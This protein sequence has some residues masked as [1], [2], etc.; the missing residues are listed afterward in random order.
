MTGPAAL[1]HLITGVAELVAAAAHWRR[2]NA[3]TLDTEF[4]RT[5]T[6]YPR[7]ALVQV[8]DGDTA[9]LIDPVA[10]GDLR[11]LGALLSD[12]NVVKVLHSCSEDLEV[13]QHA[14]GCRPAPLYDTQV[15][16][17]MVGHGFSLGYST[18]VKRLL[19]IE[20]GKQETRSDW[21]QRPLS[22]AQ[23]AYAAA[24][25]QHLF[26]VYHQ[27]VEVG[28]RLGRTDWIA[29]EMAAILAQ[30][31][32]ETPPEQQYRR[33]KG[34]GRLGGRELAA[35]R[36]LAAWR[37]GEARRRDRPRGHIV[38]DVEL[39]ALVQA[40]PADRAA[41]ARIDDLRPRTARDHGAELL[42][43]LAR[44]AQVPAAEFPEPLDGEP[45]SRSARDL[46]RACRDW[47][48]ERAAAIEIAPEMLVRRLDLEQLARSW[49]GG[50]PQLPAV[51]AVGWRH[52]LVGTELLDFVR[53]W[54]AASP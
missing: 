40:R 33:V 20:I 49:S 24:D 38:N 26:P 2:C 11:P 34:A 10:L 22:A 28:A 39:L 3:V 31:A 6:F 51:L 21:L 25:V 47:L 46:V 48:A 36:E 32:Q 1:A 8:S 14:L 29:A 4:M 7:L 12:P 16:A 42:A 13:L 5:D 43:A 30:A 19:D 9:W 54:S 17:A 52:D 35:L 53:A 15:A 37:E 45:L 18:L 50:V 44:A 23:L 27:L 41:L